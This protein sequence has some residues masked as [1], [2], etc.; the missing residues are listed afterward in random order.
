MKD[1]LTANVFPKQ[2]I[3]WA[4]KQVVNSTRLHP[5]LSIQKALQESQ[6]DDEDVKM[7][8]PSSHHRPQKQKDR[9][10]VATDLIVTEKTVECIVTAETVDH[11]QTTCLCIFILVCFLT[12]ATS[13]ESISRMTKTP[14]NLVGGVVAQTHQQQADLVLVAPCGFDVL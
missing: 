11:T 7:A 4:V 5:P 13:T 6:D 1:K 9:P 12:A 2:S 14:W 10:A 8:P 3:L